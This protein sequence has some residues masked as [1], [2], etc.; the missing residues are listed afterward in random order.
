ML[1]FSELYKH[2]PVALRYSKGADE[3]W[4]KRE[5]HWPV[6]KYI[7]FTLFVI[8]S[9]SLNYKFHEDRAQEFSSCCFEALLHPH[10]CAGVH[11]EGLEIKKVVNQPWALLSQTYSMLGKRDMQASAFEPTV[12]VLSGNDYKEVWKEGKEDCLEEEALA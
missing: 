2:A 3:Q 7:E 10:L 8:R 12:I 9:L 1:P 11:A 6:F 4:Q 5:T